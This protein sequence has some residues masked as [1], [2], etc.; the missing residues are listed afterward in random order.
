MDVRLTTRQPVLGTLS[1][2][3]NNELRPGNKCPGAPARKNLGRFQAMHGHAG[4]SAASGVG[5]SIPSPVDPKL[6]GI[7]HVDSALENGPSR[8]L[9]CFLADF[10]LMLAFICAA[11]CQ[12]WD[13]TMSGIVS[14][15]RCN[16]PIRLVGNRGVIQTAIMKL[17]VLEV[18][19][20]AVTS[21]QTTS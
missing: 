4:P 10:G 8:R 18:G 13:T 11:Q 20:Q 15:M 21:N 17:K 5:Q 19:C 9:L 3:P 7:C 16:D 14:G 6:G 2:A 1:A 12:V